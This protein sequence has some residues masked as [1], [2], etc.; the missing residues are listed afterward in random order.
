QTHERTDVCIIGAGWSGL[1]AA[2][3]MVE[4]GLSVVL[5]E[6][7][8][9]LGGVWRYSPD[10][11]L[12]TVMES[13][14]T[15]SSAAVTEASD[16]PMDP[17]VGNFVHHRD[18]LDYLDRYA[19]HFDLKRRIRFKCAALEATRVG[20][21][22]QVRC[23]DRRVDARF[24]V[25]SAGL[26]Q[27]R[28]ALRG[29]LAEFTGTSIHAGQ[30]KSI[31][32]ERFGAGDRV[33]VYGGGESASDVVEQLAKTE[34]AITWAI[35]Q[36]QHFFRKAAWPDRPGPG[37]YH[38][39][40]SPLDEASSRCIQLVS[41]FH[42]AKPG[43]RW[44]CLYG[45]TGSLLDYEGHGI[46]QWRKG[47]PF[48]RAFINKNGHVVELVKAGRVRAEGALARVDGRAVTFASGERE[49]FTHVI[50]CTG[51]RAEFPFLPE[52]LR[53]REIEGRFKMIFDPDDPSVAFIGYARPTVGSLP[54]HPLMYFAEAQHGSCILDV[55][56]NRLTLINIRDDGEVS[57]HVT[58][59]KGQGIE[60]FAPNG[61]EA[62]TVG[63]V[64]EIGWATVGPIAEVGLDYSIDDGLTWMPIADAV[65]N[66]GV[67]P[68]LVPPV[69]TAK[70]LVRVK[71][72]SDPTIY[73][74]SN[75]SFVVEGG[76][77]IGAIDFGAEWSY[78][79]Q[80]VDLG[81]A[82]RM[83]GYDFK[84]WPSG[85]AQLGYGEGDEATAIL[86]ADPNYPSAYFLRTFDVDQEI[87]GATL[88]VL[89]DDGAA[90]WLNGQLV[91]SVNA[92]DLAYDA[93]ASAQSDDNAVAVFD[94]A[95]APNPLVMGTNVIGVMVKQVS[96][97]SSDLSFD[98]KLTLI[99]PAVEPETTGGETEGGEG[100]TA[101]GGSSGTASGGSTGASSATGTAGDDGGGCA[102][103]SRE[104]G[105]R[106]G[107]GIGASLLVLLRRRRRRV[108]A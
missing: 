32:R 88:E 51:Y 77:E 3:H 19:A 99:A 6:G 17:A 90:V 78:H 12:V 62:L 48:M 55:H 26:H 35:P 43:M 104:G 24:L 82:W 21:R 91:A 50:A 29:P 105:E 95:L 94:L 72:V 31:D 18:I 20:D 56:Q 108:R 37:R 41:P 79:D 34:A 84:E 107:L 100:T 74:E 36:G 25:V 67:Y 49:V 53:E 96:G 60:I 22:W 76:V 102:C 4:N 47:V 8:E 86:D 75:A 101:G 11:E 16:F 66:T 81:D 61:G 5:L 2:R 44:L 103:R 1:L 58:L 92:D 71:A 68:W 7:R 70:G 45:S 73:D 97:D 33:L 23:S 13:T 52:A 59:I 69:D 30:L 38:Q 63:G 42:R 80:G 98:L 93:W 46:P 54:Q 39:H 40:D 15:S 85:P 14:I 27:R 87:V 28:K 57:D 9:G 64:A 65:P 89:H 83:P 10:P 106:L